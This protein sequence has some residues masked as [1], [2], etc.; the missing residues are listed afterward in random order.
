MGFRLGDQSGHLKG[1]E[2]YIGLEIRSGLNAAEPEALGQVGI[3]QS[4]PVDG[5][6]ALLDSAGNNREFVG[7]RS[8]IP[9]DRLGK[10]FVEGR[11]DAEEALGV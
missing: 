8:V 7:C 1:A 3:L 5:D 4:L 10:D 11:E 6:R 2:Q 9:D